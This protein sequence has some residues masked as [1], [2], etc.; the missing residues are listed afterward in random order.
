MAD[1]SLILV[2]DHEAI[3]DSTRSAVLNEELN[4]AAQRAATGPLDNHL[5]GRASEFIQGDLGRRAVQT[6][7]QDLRYAFRSPGHAASEVGVR[8]MHPGHYQELGLS[9]EEA[10]V[11]ASQ[12]MQT[13]D[14][15]Y[16]HAA[17]SK[18]ASRI[19][20]AFR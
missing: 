15:E 2:K 3:P 5:R 4:H 1:K 13:L 16:G 18:I 11:L 20:D 8:L 6:L 7:K 12:Y 9:R 14:R 10:R 17:V 19:N